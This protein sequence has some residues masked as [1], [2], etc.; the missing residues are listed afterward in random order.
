MCVIPRIFTRFLP[1]LCLVGVITR[2]F[3][4]ISENSHAEGVVDYG[5]TLEIV[6]TCDCGSSNGYRSR[7]WKFKFSK[8][9]NEVGKPLSITVVN[10]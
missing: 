8:F 9:A 2:I 1:V 5:G 3:L 10:I 7:L 4:S 6:L